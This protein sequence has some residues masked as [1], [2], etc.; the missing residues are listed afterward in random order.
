MAHIPVLLQTSIDGLGIKSGDIFV[1]AT[2]GLGGHSQAVAEKFGDDVKI[3]GIDQDEEALRIAR[4]RLGKITK[5]FTAVQGNFRNIDKILE[6]LGIEK[7]NRI[8]FD[9][10]VSS[11]QLDSSGRGFT[12]QK[13]EPL[14]MT[15]AGKKKEEDAVAEL[16]KNILT[17]REVVN[18]WDEENLS[19]IIR[20]FGEERYAGKIAHA[21]A[22]S[23]KKKPIETT[24]ELVDI[25][26]SATPFSYHR[27]R[28]HPATR[29][30]QAIRIAVNDELGAIEEGLKKGFNLLLPEGRIAVI[31]FHSLEDRIAKRLFNELIKSGIA[32]RITKKP[33]TASI[34]EKEANPRS[35]SAKLRIIQKQ[36]ND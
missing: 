31:S 16:N 3:I 19:A 5:N 21:I 32:D 30:F 11:L 4:E 26:K 34:E 6:D 18:E 1:D 9:L 28:I 2:L 29:T 7:V 25:V 36:K 8:L 35:R 12:F 23:R 20:G 10:G 24:F 13:D 15:L 14:V 33:I 17:A 22:E 27:G